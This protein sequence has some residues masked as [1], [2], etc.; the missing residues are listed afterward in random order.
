MKKKLIA[1]Y[2][3]R[4]HLKMCYHCDSMAQRVKKYYILAEPKSATDIRLTYLD[5][6]KD[7]VGVVVNWQEEKGE[8]GKT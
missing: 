5:C 1:M 8:N 6:C 3:D 4:T 7:E 2:S